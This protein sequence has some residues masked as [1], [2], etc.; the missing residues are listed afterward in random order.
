MEGDELHGYLLGRPVACAADRRAAG[1]AY[2]WMLDDVSDANLWP[3]GLRQQVF[4]GDEAF[5]D[6][7]P[8]RLQSARGRTAKTD[9]APKGQTRRTASLDRLLAE[10]H[11]RDKALLQ[12]YRDAGFT[13]NQIARHLGL[14]VSR[15]SRLIARKEA[16]GKT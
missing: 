1:A 13:M 9:G 14:S 16:R 2:A 8:D 4:H 7:T 12:A 5:V 11:D 6:R 15:V 10:A 3:S